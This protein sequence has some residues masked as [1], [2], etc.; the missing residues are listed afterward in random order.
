MDLL[1]RRDFLEESLRGVVGMAVPVASALGPRQEGKASGPNDRLRIACIGV[2]GQ[3]CVHVNRWAGMKDV[4]VVAVCDVDSTVVG[5]A[6]EAVETKGGRKPRYVSDLRK[7]LEDKSIDAVSIATPN[8]WHV[9]AGLWAIQAGKDVYV[10]KPL[11]HNLREGRKL[12]EAAR[13]YGRIVQE[14][15]WQRSEA[16]IR[17]GIEFLHSGKVGKIKRVRALHYY[18]R[19]S[20]GKKA[21]APVPDGVDFDLWLGPAPVR[22]FNPNRFHYNWHWAWD[23]GNGE[24]GNNGVYQ[25]D[26]ARWGLGKK[27]LPRRVWAFGGRFGPEDDGQTPNTQVA[28]FDYGDVH[29]VAEIRGLDTEDFR[30]VAMGTL[31][32]CSEGDVIFSTT[33][34]EAFTSEG[35]SIQKFAGQ[36]DHYRNFVD[37]VRSRRPGD[38]HSEVLEGHLSS[39]LCHLANASYRLGTLRSL[40][41]ENPFDEPAEA[42]EEFFRFRDH[43]ARNGVKAD[44]AQYWMGRSLTF[45]PG[46]ETFVGDAEANRFLRRDYREPFVVP[47]RV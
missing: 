8:H 31:F 45:D 41:E 3:G 36:G 32:E 10:E 40:G 20:I 7:L 26:T 38:L 44:Q 35:E 46:S 34:V 28:L 15:N 37:A 25:L 16:A 19:P 11:S 33:G 6:L 4:E 9:L 29:I 5:D 24:M 17:Q 39:G 30:G 22:A 43:L 14:G 1:T 18:K 27:E 13:K 12:V 23:Y 21:D 2:R 47:D 42:N